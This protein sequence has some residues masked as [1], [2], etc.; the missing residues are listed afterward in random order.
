MEGADGDRTNKGWD[1][2]DVLDVAATIDDDDD[3]LVAARGG[4]GLGSALTQKLSP[5]RFRTAICNTLSV[6]SYVTTTN[7]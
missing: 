1:G 3:A 7:Q 5:I 6:A 2:N 4:D